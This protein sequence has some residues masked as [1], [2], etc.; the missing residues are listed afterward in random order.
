MIENIHLYNYIDRLLS[1]CIWSIVTLLGLITLDT[2]FLNN[3][4]LKSFMPL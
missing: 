3:A 1:F 2:L 4:I